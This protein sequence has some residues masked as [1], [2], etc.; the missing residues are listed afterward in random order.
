MPQP[1]YKSVGFEVTDLKMASGQ[2]QFSGYASTFGNVDQGGDVVLRGA[3]AESI[4]QRFETKALPKTKLLWQHDSDEPIGQPVVLKEDDRGLYSE[5][6]LS[7]TT[8]GNDA[9]E[10]LKDG[11]LDSLSI[12][13]IPEDVE[14]DDAG[15]RKLKKVDLMEVSIVSFPMNEQALI[16]SVKAQLESMPFDL[17]CKRIAAFLDKGVAEAK[18]LRARRTAEKRELSE[19]HQQAIDEVMAQAEAWLSELKALRDIR[20]ETPEAEAPRSMS[21]RLEIARRRLALLGVA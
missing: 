19:R 21:H 18:A 7:R 6:K 9:Y 13:Y 17:A 3:F 16:T 10:L 20:T 11:V 12:G 8:R 14:Y 5:F 1:E 15:I 4:R 2:W